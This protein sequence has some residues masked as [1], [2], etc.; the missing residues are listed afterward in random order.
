MFILACGNPHSMTIV[1]QC[2][3]LSGTAHHSENSI[4][5]TFLLT[6]LF[7]PALIDNLIVRD[8]NDSDNHGSETQLQNL[9]EKAQYSMR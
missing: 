7:F 3:A 8:D 2:S 1:F 5:P 6:L 4:L 9:N